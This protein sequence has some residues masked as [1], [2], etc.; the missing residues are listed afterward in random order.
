M[1]RIT[2]NKVKTIG[3]REGLVICTT[4]MRDASLRDQIAEE[5]P[6]LVRKSLLPSDGADPCPTTHWALPVLSG[7]PSGPNASRLYERARAKS[8]GPA[9]I[10]LPR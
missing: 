4:M 2:S 5:C 9:N 7:A 10:S 1:K 8:C 6:M 3:P